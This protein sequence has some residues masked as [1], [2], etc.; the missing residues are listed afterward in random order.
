M[1][2]KR[3]ALIVLLILLIAAVAYGVWHY[4]QQQE[5]PLT[6]YGNVDIRTVNLGFRVDGRLASLT[7]DEGDTVQPGQLLGKL[8][9]APYRNALQQAEANVGSARAKLSLLQAGYRS[10]EIA[11]VQSEMAQR[12]SAFAYADSFLKRQQGLWAKN[13]TSADALEDART[14]RN[15][16]EANLQAAKDKL[17][18]YRSGNRPQEIEQAKAEVAQSEA[19]LAQAQ[20]NLQDATLLS[21]SA[22]TVL[23]RAVE[24]GTMLGAGGTVFTLSLTRP[25][26]VRAYVNETSLNQAVPG[27][28]LEIY[29]DGRPG[30]P[31][32]GKIGFVSPTAEFTPKSVETP[33]LRTDLVYRLRVIVTDADDA[34]RQGMPVT[35]RFAKP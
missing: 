4:Q 27:T 29:T 18:Q 33:D 13:A 19:A 1:N 32:H 8:D 17:S 6:L 28:E 14:A 9:D 30:K 21:P 25:V 20:L 34:L 3:S 12:Q 16:A 15:Q 11:Q 26:W 7:V 23:T 24:P 35:L 31:Y 5:R 2:K 10:E 22:G